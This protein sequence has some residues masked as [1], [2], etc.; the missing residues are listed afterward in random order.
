M[1]G[2]Q[3]CCLKRW[4]RDPGDQNE[5][6]TQQ[7]EQERHGVWMLATYTPYSPT[8]RETFARMEKDHGALSRDPAVRAKLIYAA[9]ADWIEAM[10]LPLVRRLQ[11]EV[12][13][14]IRARLASQDPARQGKWY[15]LGK[16]R[17]YAYFKNNELTCNYSLLV[18]K[19][20]ADMAIPHPFV[21]LLVAAQA[22]AQSGSRAGSPNRA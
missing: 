7:A 18:P 4:S 5:R 1:A 13:G 21:I 12:Q 2:Q 14:G 20:S 16:T 22:A 3:C 19:A 9:K 17:G 10:R 11:T 6:K 8:L 15:P